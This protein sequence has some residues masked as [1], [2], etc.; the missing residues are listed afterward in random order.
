M[1]VTPPTDSLNYIKEVFQY[2]KTNIKWDGTYSM[3]ASHD[4]DEVLKKKE[5]SSG[6]MNLLL[7]NVLRKAG[8]KANP[9]LIRTSNLGRIENLYPEK[10][11]FNHVIVQ[12]ELNGRTMYLDATG[13]SNS[14][15]L[16]AN[17]IHTVGWLLKEQ[18]FKW[19]EVEDSTPTNIVTPATFQQT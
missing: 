3:Y 5:G 9:V 8:F 1:D 10:D 4:F 19:V 2:I 11:Q 7:L 6:E 14:L 12:V 17:V 15:A 16:P 13:P 18:G